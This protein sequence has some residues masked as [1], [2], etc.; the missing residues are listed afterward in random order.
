MN[1]C[2]PRLIQLGFICPVI[3]FTSLAFCPIDTTCRY[4]AVWYRQFFF[5]SKYSLLLKFDLVGRSVKKMSMVI[6]S[7]LLQNLA[8]G[9]DF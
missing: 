1:I 5:F 7:T 2:K 4:L 6:R 9:L 8:H 3:A